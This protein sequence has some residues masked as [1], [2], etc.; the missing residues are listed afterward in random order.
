MT[1]RSVRKAPR[2]HFLLEHGALEA[3]GNCLVDHMAELVGRVAAKGLD[4]DLQPPRRAE[5]RL[6]ATAARARGRWRLLRRRGGSRLADNGLAPRLLRRRLGLVAARVVGAEAERAADI[7]G[8][9]GPGGEGAEHVVVVAV[10][11]GVGVDRECL[12]RL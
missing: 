1:A 5:L 12:G 10:I 9:I 8:Q 11:H 3:E 2:G 6:P 4:I 7:L